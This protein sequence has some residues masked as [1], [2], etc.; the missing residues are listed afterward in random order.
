MSKIFSLLSFFLVFFP[1]IIFSQPNVSVKVY[2]LKESSSKE[3]ANFEGGNLWILK[4]RKE[5]VY[6]VNEEIRIFSFN[7]DKLVEKNFLKV[8]E[9]QIS[10]ISQH[11]LKI[12]SKEKKDQEKVVFYWDVSLNGQSISALTIDKDNTLIFSNNAGDL[13]FYNLSKKSIIGKVNI[14]KGDVISLNA[15]KNGSL[16]LIYKNGN[17]IFLEKKVYPILSFFQTLKDTY[18][19]RGMLNTENSTT[20]FMDENENSD[21]IFLLT[22]HKTLAIYK[23]PELIPI[24][25]IKDD[26]FVEC[27]CFF[28]NRLLYSVIEE[29][30]IEGTF[31]FHKHFSIL[32]NFYEKKKNIIPSS[33]GRKFV[34][35]PNLSSIRVYNLLTERLI[36]EIGINVKEISDIKFSVNEEYLIIVTKKSKINIY[37]IL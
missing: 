8:D 16:I 21:E 24:K 20:K 9:N 4:E 17:V 28:E 1:S 27:A 5:I 14:P 37:K 31:S 7:N 30:K 23:I 6:F 12:D 2:D 32:S 11:N 35:I 33:L 18:L 29:G 26:K 13:F 25:T 34:Y 10:N 3:L 36:G 19:I 22:G 15:L